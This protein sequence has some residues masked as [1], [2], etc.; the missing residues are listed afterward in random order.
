LARIERGR[1]RRVRGK[2]IFKGVITGER[3]E[4]R[5]QGGGKGERL[6]S[7]SSRRE[8]GIGYGP[9]K[10]KGGLRDRERERRKRVEQN[11]IWGGGRRRS[12]LERGG[13]RK[14]RIWRDLGRVSNR[15]GKK[16]N[17]GSRATQHFYLTKGG[18]RN[19]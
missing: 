12:I 6:I 4:G 2:S 17:R 9:K 3:T 15:D 5:R 7:S 13:I 19:F 14:P 11:H 16:G 10:E 8:K 18:E 1:K